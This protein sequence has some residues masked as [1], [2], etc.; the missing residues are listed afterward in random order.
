MLLSFLLFY[1]FTFQPLPSPVQAP[2]HISLLFA[3]RRC[4][5]T[6][7]SN[8]SSIPLPWGIKLPQQAKGSP[9]L[10]MHQEGQRISPCIIPGGSEGFG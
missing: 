4:S 1:L 6:H 2:Y 8:P 10:H 7:P 3:L 5:H 9:L